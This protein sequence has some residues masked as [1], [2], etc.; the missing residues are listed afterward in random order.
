MIVLPKSGKKKIFQLVKQITSRL[1][2]SWF[3]AFRSRYDTT[4]S[5]DPLSKAVDCEMF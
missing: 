4:L 2:T 1:S 3:L 5:K